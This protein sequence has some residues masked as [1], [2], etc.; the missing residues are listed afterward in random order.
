MEGMGQP[1]LVTAGGGRGSEEKEADAIGRLHDLQLSMCIDRSGK[2][3]K[4]H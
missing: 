2:T 3:F 4:N 1:K